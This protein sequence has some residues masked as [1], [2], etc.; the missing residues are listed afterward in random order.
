MM[1]RRRRFHEGERIAENRLELDAEGNTR[2]TKKAV[3]EVNT[4][5]A[6][7]MNDYESTME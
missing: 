2:D 6:R 1:R 4:S 7:M 5:R 3:S